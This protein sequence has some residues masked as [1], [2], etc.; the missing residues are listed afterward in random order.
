MIILTLYN[1]IYIYAIICIVCSIQT[2]TKII[3]W[4]AHTH[5]PFVII[6]VDHGYWYNL[7]CSYR[8]LIPSPS[9]HGPGGPVALEE[10]LCLQSTLHLSLRRAAKLAELQGIEP[11][12]PWVVGIDGNWSTGHEKYQ[13]YFYDI[14][15]W[16]F[17]WYSMV[18]L[19]ISQ[20][21]RNTPWL[22]LTVRH[23]IDGP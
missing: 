16:L 9:L 14:M 7:R 8:F 15:K 1:I 17:L 11:W 4:H 12:Q 5:L 10:A 19:F 18:F 2:C 22:W 23:G 3:F 6:H 20:W 21:N 13:G